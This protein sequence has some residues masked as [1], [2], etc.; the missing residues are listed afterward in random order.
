MGTGASIEPRTNAGSV[1]RS[2]AGTFLLA[3][4]VAIALELGA[5]AIAAPN[6]AAQALARGVEGLVALE[7]QIG[8]SGTALGYQIQF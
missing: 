1:I 8:R 3:G 4:L 2:I 6:S 5:M 7:R